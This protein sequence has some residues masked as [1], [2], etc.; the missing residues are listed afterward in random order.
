MMGSHDPPGAAPN[1]EGGSAA[2]FISRTDA[3]P[4]SREASSHS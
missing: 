2:A 4:S 1:L 3:K